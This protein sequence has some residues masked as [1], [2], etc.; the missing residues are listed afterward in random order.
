MFKGTETCDEV[1][2]YNYNLHAQVSSFWIYDIFI[3][4]VFTVLS[5]QSEM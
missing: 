4:S 1:Y 2:S 3:L 5:S